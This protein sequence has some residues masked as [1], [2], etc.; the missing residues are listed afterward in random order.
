M[1][2]EID[3]YWFKRDLR[4]EDNEALWR[5]SQSQR[6]ILLIYIVEPDLYNDIHYSNRHWRFVMES[7]DDLNNTLRKYQTNILTVYSEVIPFLEILSSKFI[8]NTIFSTEE[9]GIAI[10]YQRDLEVAKFCKN[11]N[12]IWNESKNGGVQRGLNNRSNWKNRWYRYMNTEIKQISLSNKEFIKLKEVENLN[13]NFSYPHD[14]SMQKGGRT[15][16]KEW[17]DSFFKERVAYYSDYISKPELARFGCS[18][19]S[20]Y[21]AYGCISIREVYQ[22]SIGLK[23][24]GK[25]KK[26]LTAFNS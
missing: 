9:T 10:T 12:I 8:I 5:A 2:D 1:K 18:R 13:F 3:I 24:E 11:S 22:R 16:G 19:L 14:H 25:F 21:F 7:L 6:P 23:Q 20:P 4:L 17:E 26:Q 15:A